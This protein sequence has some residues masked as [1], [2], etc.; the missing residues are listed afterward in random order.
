MESLKQLS[1]LNNADPRNA[2]RQIADGPSASR[3]LTLGD[4][5][6]LISAIQLHDAVPESIRSHFSQAQ[7]LAVYAWFHFPFHVTAEFMALV[8]VEYALRVRYRSK[9]TFGQLLARARDDGLLKASK[10][11]AANWSEQIELSNREDLVDSLPKLRNELAHGS[12][13]L[14]PFSYSALRT[15]AHLINRLFPKQNEG[16]PHLPRQG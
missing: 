13:N 1:E 16:G 7:N 9:A 2:A 5:H 14:H 3:P 15:C 4:V 6:K 10:V 8:S 12:S 11:K